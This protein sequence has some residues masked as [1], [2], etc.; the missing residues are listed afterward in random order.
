MTKGSDVKES[1]LRK[2]KSIIMN[3]H[4]EFQGNSILRKETTLSLEVQL[5]P[6]SNPV[7]LTC[8][9]TF[10]DAVSQKLHT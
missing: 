8:V 2:L 3:V 1:D 10:S 6:G 4:Q 5:L 9:F 7:T